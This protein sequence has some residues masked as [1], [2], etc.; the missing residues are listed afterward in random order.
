MNFF[1]LST[2]LALASLLTVVRAPDYAWVWKFTI[3]IDEF[4][5]WIVLL[6]LGLAVIASFASRGPWRVVTLVLCAAATAGL[7]RPVFSA[8]RLAATLPAEMR[9]ALGTNRSTDAPFSYRRLYLG[10]GR[11]EVR[12]T[13]E[14]YARPDGQD[15]KLDFYAPPFVKDTTRR[16]PCVIVIHGGGWDSGDRLQLPELNHRLAAHGYA[17]A[18]IDYRLAPRWQWPA[19]KEDTLVAV[20]WLKKN[21]DRLGLDPSRLVLLGRSAGAQIAEVAG[22]ATHDPA[23]RG[24]ISFYG[25]S[26]MVFAYRNAP[27]DDAIRSPSLIR[28]LLG[29]TPEQQLARYDD[30]SALRFVTADSP[31]TLMLHGYLDTLARHEHNVRLSARLTAAGVPHYFL[32]LPWATHAFDFNLDGPGGQLADYAIDQFLSAVTR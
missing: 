5:H 23:V 9:A 27:E 20:A 4:G 25:P 31:P 14:V 21:A 6:P 18:A 19:Q 10:P 2:A 29:G 12:V 8:R 3:L 26:D 17:V 11:P 7:L 16:P 13:T 30:A 28:A 22:Y 24:V 15:L 1:I 32:S